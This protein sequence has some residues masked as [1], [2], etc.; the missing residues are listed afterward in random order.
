[1]DMTNDACIRAMLALLDGDMAAY[2]ERLRGYRLSY[3]D[4][5]LL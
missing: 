1:M 2:P 5:G 3:I 4:D